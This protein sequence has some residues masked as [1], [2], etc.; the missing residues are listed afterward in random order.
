MFVTVKLSED[1]PV[2]S[3][4]K[5]DSSGAYVISNTSTYPIGVVIKAPIQDSET[6][7]W[8]A[9]VAFAGSCHA[10]AHASIPEEGGIL[11]VINGR[12]HVSTVDTH[13][14]VIA[15]LSLG[16]PARQAGD[17]VLVHLR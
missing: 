17:L 4:V 2:G 3:V 7:E 15:P 13:S 8:S 1:L 6:Q 10:L 12:V 9:R 11:E 14:G 5:Y 16:E